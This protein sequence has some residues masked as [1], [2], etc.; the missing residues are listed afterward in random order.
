MS[1]P[2]LEPDDLAD[3]T[4]PIVEAFYF[5]RAGAE[6]RLEIT[7]RINDALRSW[8]D[9]T[10]GRVRLSDGSLA[11]PVDVRAVIDPESFDDA[12]NGITISLARW[13]AVCKG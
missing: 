1:R 8:G 7:R 12:D 2:I 5:A 3:L 10:G 6:T 9:D 11:E 13:R 4:T